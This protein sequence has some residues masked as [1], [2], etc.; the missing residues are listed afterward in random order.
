VSWRYDWQPPSGSA[1]A[2]LYEKFL[3][4]RDWLA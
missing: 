3:M 1:E 2:A 4:P